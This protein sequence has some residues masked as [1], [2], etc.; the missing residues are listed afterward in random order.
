M[1][2]VR[3]EGFRRG[4]TVH[5]FTDPQLSLVKSDSGAINLY[6]RVL[7]QIRED[8]VQPPG[9]LLQFSGIRSGEYLMATAYES[10]AAMHEGF[11]TYAFPYFLKD[12]ER[13]G[14]RRDI[15]RSEFSLLHSYISPSIERHTFGFQPANGAVACISDHA[16]PT[17]SNYWKVVDS[18]PW[19]GPQAPQL[20]HLAY[21]VGDVVHAIDIWPDRATG[22]AFYADHLQEQ[23]EALQPG[24]L[25]EAVWAESWIELDAFV[26][27]DY[28]TCAMS[29][30]TRREDADESEV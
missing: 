21:A 14:A 19:Q 25:S 4:I 2:G 22:E 3:Y 9:L 30:Y 13:G 6:R 8:G 18:E 5:V 12:M 11:M 10:R 15:D 20:A 29:R 17:I 28:A 16:Q 26:V 24:A 7:T 1:D 23:F 27:T